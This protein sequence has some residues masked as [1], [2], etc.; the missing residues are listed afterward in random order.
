MYRFILTYGLRARFLPNSVSAKTVAVLLWPLQTAICL[1][2]FCCS[3]SFT[4]IHNRI[5]CPE[6][7]G[8]RARFWLNSVATKTVGVTTVTV[9]DGY[10]CD[11]C[12]LRP[13]LYMQFCRSQKLHATPN[14]RPGLKAL[15]S[16]CLTPID[17]HP[18]IGAIYVYINK[19][20]YRPRDG[21]S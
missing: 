12:R 5:K 19:Y 16:Q 6:L 15:E 2:R 3:Q 11:S 9:I 10:I 20:K 17:I 14:T 4:Q 13:G 8:P 18:N 7:I 21:C 1:T